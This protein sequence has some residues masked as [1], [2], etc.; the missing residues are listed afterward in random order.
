MLSDE[1]AGPLQARS[2]EGVH[3]DA[4]G[5]A[6]HGC[7]DIPYPVGTTPSN[8]DRSCRLLPLAA[9]AEEE[10]VMPAPSFDFRSLPPGPET[11][12]GSAVLVRMVEGIGFRF[13]WATEGL[14]ESDLSFRPTPETMSIA[15][16]AGH[17]LDLVAWV[18]LSAGAIPAGPREPERPLPFPEARQRVLEVLSLLRARFAGMSDEEIG[19]IRIGS[20]A[21]PVPW[22]HLVNGP[23]A[24]ALTHVGQ[25]N[26]LRRASGNPVPKANVFLG[27]PPTPL[28]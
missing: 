17:V 7:R 6:T 4:A 26:V 24:D 11:V 22:P 27:R 20:R 8:R 15:D 18:A 13:F 14:R 12:T 5:L 25:I 1:P 16:L 2:R 3:A 23:L 28:S 10:R 9:A 19:T 21:G